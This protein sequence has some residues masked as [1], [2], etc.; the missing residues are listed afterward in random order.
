MTIKITRDA[1]MDT[2]EKKFPKMWMKTSEEWN[3]E[4]N[5]IWTGE[6]SEF[7]DEDGFPWMMFNHYSEDFD[8]LYYQMGV[9]KELV[10]FL[11]KYGWYCDFYDAGT[12]FIY[13]GGE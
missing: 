8:E 6:G 11:D 12:V 4:E 10:H 1:L 13:K 9:K 5:F 3:G 7:I 2:L